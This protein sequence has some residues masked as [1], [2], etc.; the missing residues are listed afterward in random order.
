M[1]QRESRE[2]SFTTSVI[3]QEP[4]GC[5]SCSIGRVRFSNLKSQACG[6]LKP[7]EAKASNALAPSLK[8]AQHITLVAGVADC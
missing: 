1:G 5:S 2:R 4:A 7:S 6:E 3:L 8:S